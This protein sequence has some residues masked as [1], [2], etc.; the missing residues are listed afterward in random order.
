M[1]GAL[2]IFD[3]HNDVLLNLAIPAR[4]KGRSFFERSDIGHIDLPRARAGGLAG[5]LFAIFVP[6][7]SAM[8]TGSAIPMEDVAFTP[9]GYSVKLGEAVSHTHALRVT[10]DVLGLLFRIQVES[11]GQVRVVRSAD[12]LAGALA[13]GA[14]AV[15]LHFEGAEAI[16]PALTLLPDFYAEGLRSLGI[17][18]SRPNAFGTG[19]PFRYPAS[20]DTGPGL[21][22]AG[23]ALTRACNELG[24]VID[25][26]HINERGFWDVSGISAAPLVV[27]HAGVHAICASTRNITDKQ[28]DAI[29]E[30]GGI[31]GIAYDVSMLRPDGDIGRDMPLSVLADHIAYVADRIGIAHVGLGSDFDGADMPETLADASMLPNLVAALRARGFDAAALRAIA[32]ENWERVLR[33]TWR[34]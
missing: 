31:V 18:W 21:T 19:V 27:T 16:D 33:A 24:I 30:T 29:G 3:G 25:L 6:P 15:V 13:A 22:E 5:G 9:R 4:G 17:V 34:E 1:T 8:I 26:A 12:E 20:P 11:Q 14:L 10:R 7:E 32:Y 23:R 28:L 2:P